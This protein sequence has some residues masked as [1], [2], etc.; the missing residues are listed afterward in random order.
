MWAWISSTRSAQFTNNVRG[1]RSQI[2][3]T[4]VVSG[5]IV[6][7][8]QLLLDLDYLGVEVEVG[9]GPG[10]VEVL[11]HQVAPAAAQCPVRGGC[12][13][14]VNSPLYSL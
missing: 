8:E 9:V 5:M 12:T 3:I 10:P 13:V 6:I 11:P 7:E 1:Q 2:V 14:T 4:E